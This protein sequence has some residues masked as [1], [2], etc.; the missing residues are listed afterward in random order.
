MTISLASPREV[1]PLFTC[2]PHEPTSFPRAHLWAALNTGVFFILDRSPSVCVPFPQSIHPLRS[3]KMVKSLCLRHPFNYI[4]SCPW[5]PNLQFLRQ[6]ILFFQLDLESHSSQS[7]AILVLNIF[8]SFFFFFFFFTVLGLELRT[9]T[10]SHP[11]SPF[12]W[13]V[14]SR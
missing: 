9:F 10:L 11:T 6:S 14:F 3:H 12:L 5:T 8:C 2:Y 1:Q 4:T 13:W 7:S